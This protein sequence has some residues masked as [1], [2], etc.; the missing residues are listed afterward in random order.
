MKK[1]KNIALILVLS[2]FSLVMV[3]CTACGSN[4]D[5]FPEKVELSAAMIKEIE[6]ENDEAVKLEQKDNSVKITGTINKMSKSQKQAFGDENATHVVVIKVNFDKERTL[7]Y[8]KLKG[9]KTKVYSDDAS[10]ENYTGKISDLL[11]SEDGEDAYC[12]LILSASTP[13]YELTIKYTD[14]E[15]VNMTVEIVA[16]LAT[17]TAE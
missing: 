16:T 15:T 14:G 5:K 1:L 11:D 2:I 13:K 12:N 7:S 3:A 8:F 10:V 9:E 6:F 17:A 4:E